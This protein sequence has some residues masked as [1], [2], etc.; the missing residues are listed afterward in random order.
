MQ[1]LNLS[2]SYPVKTL[3]D[4][5]YIFNYKDRWDPGLFCMF[6]HYINNRRM[7]LYI[8]TGYRVLGIVCPDQL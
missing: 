1:V 8:L 7:V 4:C 5:N 2:V 3:S 6:T